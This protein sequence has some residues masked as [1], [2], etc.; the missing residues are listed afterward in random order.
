MG[1]PA[2]TDTV[3]SA[4]AEIEAAL[5]ASAV[6]AVPPEFAA[7]VLPAAVGKVAEPVPAL[8]ASEG[9]AVLS[10]ALTVTA[11][12]PEVTSPAGSRLRS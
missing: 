8:A 10:E 5:L 9:A 6:A 7:A 11:V 3:L 1:V 2:G 12:L 4:A